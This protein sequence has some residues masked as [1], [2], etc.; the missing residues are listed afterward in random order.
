M[1]KTVVKKLYYC[2]VKSLSFNSFSKFKILK[3][4]GIKND[5]CI[6]F[7]RGLNKKF[8]SEYIFNPDIR[9]LNNFL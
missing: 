5:R 9:N 2:P 6:A 8:I 1:G 4:I 3:S 7:T